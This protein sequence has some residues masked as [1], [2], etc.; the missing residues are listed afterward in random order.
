MRDRRREQRNRRVPAEPSRQHEISEPQRENLGV[1]GRRV[2]KQFHRRGARAR[3][4]RERSFGVGREVPQGV[5]QPLE[6]GGVRKAEKI[7]GGSQRRRVEPQRAGREEAPQ[8]MNAPGGAGLCRLGARTPDV[9]R[10]AARHNP[11]EGAPARRRRSRL[12]GEALAQRAGER[13]IRRRLASSRARPAPAKKAGSRAS[14]WP[15]RAQRGNICSTAVDFA[16]S[17][18]RAGF[19]RAGPTPRRRSGCDFRGREERLN[20]I[21]T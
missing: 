16:A 4:R 3:G 15:W 21:A 18:T 10:R 13:R 14:R 8:P 2:A 20:R 12:Q 19:A 5:G 7:S 6:A 9:R 11:R 1:D 17:T